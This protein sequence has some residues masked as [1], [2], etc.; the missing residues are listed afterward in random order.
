M[1]Y[2]WLKYTLNNLWWTNSTYFFSNILPRF[3]F[4]VNFSIQ[5]YS[6]LIPEYSVYLQITF[7]YVYHLKYTELKIFF[8]HSVWE[9]KLVFQL[10]SPSGY[11]YVLSL[12]KVE[13]FRAWMKYRY[14]TEKLKQYCKMLT[15][16]IILLTRKKEKQRQSFW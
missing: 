12:F 5:S 9:P 4:E 8:G 1:T 6:S 11:M 13:K 7:H 10:L 3:E 14:L 16:D 2:F 15:W